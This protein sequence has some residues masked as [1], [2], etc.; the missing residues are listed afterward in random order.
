MK[1]VMLFIVTLIMCLVPVFVW[2]NWLMSLGLMFVFFPQLFEKYS[3]KLQ[4]PIAIFLPMMSSLLIASG[5]VF[6]WASVLFDVIAFGAALSFQAFSGL[7]LVSLWI[8]LWFLEMAIPSIFVVE[9]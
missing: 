6:K 5:I 1:K 4:A 7:L 9:L 2:D 8:F 3:G